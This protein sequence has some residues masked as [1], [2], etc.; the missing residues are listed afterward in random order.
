MCVY[1]FICIYMKLYIVWLQRNIQGFFCKKR[2]ILSNYLEERKDLKRKKRCERK[3]N[4]RF[5]VGGIVEW[6]I[7]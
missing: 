2:K 6:I 1:V 7:I 5:T 3:A 4:T